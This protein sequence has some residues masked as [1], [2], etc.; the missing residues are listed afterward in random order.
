MPDPSRQNLVTWSVRRLRH[1]HKLRPRHWE[2]GF[3]GRGANIACFEQRL[4]VVLLCLS[5][6]KYA[7]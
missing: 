1:P 5:S 3:Q 2:E 6:I 7:F 4:V